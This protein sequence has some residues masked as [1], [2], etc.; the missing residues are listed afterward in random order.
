MHKQEKLSHQRESTFRYLSQKPI[1]KQQFEPAVFSNGGAA[2]AVSSHGVAASA[3]SSQGVAAFAVSSHGVAAFAASSHGVAASAASS[4]GVG[5]SA[6]SSDG[7]GASGTSSSTRFFLNDDLK[8]AHALFVLEDRTLMPGQN[9][10]NIFFIV[11][12]GKNHSRNETIKDDTKIT[13]IREKKIF[14]SIWA[15]YLMLGAGRITFESLHVNG[16][17]RGFEK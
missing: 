1:I 12:I 10:N 16:L 5:V 3:V 11:K 15:L 6:G 8:L 9:N 14:L 7:A 13:K 2:F 4:H 17:E